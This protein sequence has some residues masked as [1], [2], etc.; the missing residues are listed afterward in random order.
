MKGLFHFICCFTFSPRPCLAHIQSSAH[1]YEM[2]EYKPFPGP[3][4]HKKD[5][6]VSCVAIFFVILNI[7]IIINVVTM[8][9]IQK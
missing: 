8:L 3:Q 6:N 9:G 4:I 1:I 2:N 7:L 5:G